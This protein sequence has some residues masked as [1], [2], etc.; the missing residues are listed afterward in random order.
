M[1]SLRDIRR[2]I[3]SVKN[4]AKIT[5]AME[6][7][8]ASRMR[9]AQ[10]RVIAARRYPEAMRD[11]ISELASAAGGGEGLHPLLVQRPIDTVGVVMMTSD[12]GLAGALNTNIIRRASQLIL[13]AGDQ[14]R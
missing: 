4:T 6:M 12:R 14:A 5:K 3:R 2:R 11:L 10:Q 9:R 1:P 8:A 13:E 7:V